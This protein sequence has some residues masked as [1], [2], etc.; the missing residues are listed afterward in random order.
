MTFLGVWYL[1]WL[2]TSLGGLWMARGRKDGGEGGRR[3]F[4][5]QDRA[6]RGR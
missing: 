2:A 6:L 4:W 5:A 3:R 1:G